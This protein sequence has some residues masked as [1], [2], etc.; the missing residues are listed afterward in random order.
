MQFAPYYRIVP[1]AKVA[2]LFIH[3]IVGTPAHFA[4]LIPCVPNDW[5]VYNILLDGHGAQVEDF[6]RTCIKKWKAQVSNQLDEIL[7]SHESVLIA[8][9]SMGTLFA[10]SEAIRHR[11]RVKALFLLSVPLAPRVTPR[12]AWNSL[13]AALGL[14][15]P[16]TL[17]MDMIRDSGV[18]LSPRLWEYLGWIPRYAEL[19]AEIR[20][21]RKQLHRLCVPTRTYQCRRDEL[22]SFRACKRLTGHPCIQTIVLEESGHFAYGKEDL[23]LLQKDFAELISGI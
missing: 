20:R 12:A 7:Q 4:P 8:A 11:G 17:A 1:N 3:G 21:T 9:H 16:G 22:V 5:S 15:K 23:L 10:I 14:A 6:S 13:I 18:H 2:V 19:F